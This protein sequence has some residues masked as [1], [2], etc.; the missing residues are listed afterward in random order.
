MEVHIVYEVWFCFFTKCL[1]PLLKNYLLQWRVCSIIC[2][3]WSLKKHNKGRWYDVVDR[4]PKSKIITECKQ[5]FLYKLWDSRHA[6][7]GL[8]LHTSSFTSCYTI[9]HL[10]WSV[11]IFKVIWTTYPRQHNFIVTFPW[12]S[13]V[14]LIMILSISLKF[15]LLYYYR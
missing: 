9:G 6:N 3:T 4:V 14:T 11:I 10:D 1:R 2:Y 8:S 15:F 13:S 5:H 7:I 12:S